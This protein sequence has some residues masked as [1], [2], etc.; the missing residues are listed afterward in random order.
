[1]ATFCTIYKEDSKPP[2]YY[3]NPAVLNMCETVPEEAMR[4]VIKEFFIRA[5]ID[6]A[7]FFKKGYPMASQRTGVIG[8]SEASLEWLWDVHEGRADFE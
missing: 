2:A 5:K 1:M 7:G 3:I 4:R 8:I 6:P